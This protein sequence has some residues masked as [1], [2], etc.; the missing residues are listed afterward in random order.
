MKEGFYP[1]VTSQAVKKTG[2]FNDVVIKKA[3][4]NKRH[5]KSV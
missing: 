2:H 5:I 1:K 4:L 3:L